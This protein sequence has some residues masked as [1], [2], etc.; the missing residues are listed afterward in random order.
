MTLPAEREILATVTGIARREL[1]RDGPVEPGMRLVED[2]GLDSLALLTLAVAVED[3]FE[4]CLDED[5][6]AEIATVGDLVALVRRKLAAK[7]GAGGGEPSATFP[8]ATG[9][10]VVREGTE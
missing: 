1:D 9:P 8:A 3:R 6:E 10:E 7:E 4:I 2:L 5:E